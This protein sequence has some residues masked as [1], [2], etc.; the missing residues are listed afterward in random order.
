M[1]Q[2]NKSKTPEKAPPLTF[3]DPTANIQQKRPV[4]KGGEKVVESSNQGHFRPS[5]VFDTS[6]RD[7]NGYKYTRSP[8][9][10]TAR[11]SAFSGPPRYDW[12]DVESAAAI[13]VQSIF[14]RN[15][16]LNQ[17]EK[18]GKL[19]AA[20]RN[21]IRSRQVRGKRGMASED[22]PSFLRFCGIGMLFSD[23]TG[24]DTDALNS[25]MNA[26]AQRLQEKEL[27]ESQSRKYRLRKK[28]TNQLEEAIEVVDDID[29][30]EE[31]ESNQ[32]KDVDD[33]NKKTNSKKKKGLFR[34]SRKGKV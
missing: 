8:T 28:G 15:Q 27:Q 1:F 29:L 3:E 20:M 22:V 14:R 2:R 17:L 25:P 11:E 26:G 4:T 30:E 18:E 21:R 7:E 23:A 5:D 34:F 6:L 13:K 33:N 10:P 19:T 16:V 24:E 12:V 32:I 9:V 31:E